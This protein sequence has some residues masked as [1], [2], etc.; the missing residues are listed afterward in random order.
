MTFTVYI[1]RQTL[2]WIKFLTKK[3]KPS[4]F[5]YCTMSDSRRTFWILGAR[6]VSQSSCDQHHQRN[7]PAVLHSQYQTPWCTGLRAMP[8]DVFKIHSQAFRENLIYSRGKLLETWRTWIMYATAQLWF[9]HVHR[10][11]KGGVCTEKHKITIPRYGGD[12]K[13]LRAQL[14]RDGPSNSKERH[15]VLQF[16][17]TT[18]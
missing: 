4:L 12:G 18:L 14:G 1:R 5:S 3:K 8:T 15:S 16:Q 10:A 7:R 2:I 9:W 13:S 11:Q 6:S 17:S